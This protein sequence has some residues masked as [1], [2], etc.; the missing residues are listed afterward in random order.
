MC[1]L[2]QVA[3]GSMKDFCER[4]NSHLGSLKAKHFLLNRKKKLSKKALG[5][6]IGNMRRVLQAADVMHGMTIFHSTN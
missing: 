1:H 6:A 4:D 3:Q 2:A 5:Y